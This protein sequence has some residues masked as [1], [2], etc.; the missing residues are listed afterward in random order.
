[1]VSECAENKCLDL[2]ETGGIINMAI[3][4]TDMT[5]DQC[6]SFEKADCNFS[7]DAVTCEMVGRMTTEEC[8]DFVNSFT[9]KSSDCI[10]L[11]DAQLMAIERVLTYNYLSE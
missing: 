2:Y 3:Y 1:M 4:S 10:I 6:F 8:I 11:T 5:P 7:D 9:A